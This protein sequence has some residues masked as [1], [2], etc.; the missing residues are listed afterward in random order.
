MKITAVETIYLPHG[1]NVHVG[2]INYLWVRIHTD[3]GLIGLGESYPNAEAEAAVVHSRLAAVLLGKDPGAIDRLWA[4]MFLAVA[5]SGWAGAEMRALSAVDIALWDLFGKATGQP[6][7]K[8][9]GGASRPSMRIYNTCYDRVD[10]TK[11]P[12]RFAREL[13]ASNIRA[14][15]IWPFDPFGRE[16]GGNHISADQLRRAIEPLKL[17]REEFADSIDVAIEFHGLWNLPSAKKIAAALEPYKPMWLEEMLPQD[18]LAAYAELARSTSLPLCISERLMTRW[19]FRELVENR[20]ASII[21]PDIAWCGGLSEGKKIATMAE[22]YYLPIAPHNCGG[23]IL[24]FATAH[25][26]ANVTNLYIMETVRRHYN[27]EYEGVVTQSLVPNASGELP[28]PSGPGLG[29][30]LT[31]AVLTSKDAVVRRTSL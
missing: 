9:L 24:H 21:M 25:L 3:E 18:N 30:E 14:M 27:E 23:P 26:A 20:A 11:E 6:I 13:L 10:F 31:Q 29:V 28:L 12:V 5:Y 1:I 7:Y 22:T 16:T 2:A 15:K 4:D 19:G 17:I 8:L